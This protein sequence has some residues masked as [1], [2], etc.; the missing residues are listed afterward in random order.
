MGALALGS[1]LVPALIAFGDERTPFFV[2]GAGLS[3]LVL[4]SWRS[5]ARLDADAYVPARELAL[6]RAIPIFSP[7]PGPCWSALHPRWSD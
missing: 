4:L 1:I 7:L 3:I 6:L 2:V 5:L